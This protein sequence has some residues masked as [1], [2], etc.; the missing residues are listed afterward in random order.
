MAQQVLHRAGHDAEVFPVGPTPAVFEQWDGAP[1]DF[2]CI[3]ALTPFA[4][5][6]CRS[7]CKQLKQRFPDSQVILGL[8][9]FPGALAKPKDKLAPYADKIVTSLQEALSFVGVKDHDQSCGNPGAVAAPAL[10]S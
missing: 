6:R 5:R 2:I 1:P 9:D 4:L 3:S 10:V 7:L 8:W